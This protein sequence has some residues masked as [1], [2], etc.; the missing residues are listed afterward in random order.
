MSENLISRP[1]LTI[2]L[3]DAA[4]NLNKAWAIWFRDVYAR[5]GYQGGNILNDTTESIDD[6][7]DTLEEVIIQVDINTLD[8]D[9]NSKAIEEGSSSGLVQAQINHRVYGDSQ[10]DTY[11][12]SGVSY[13]IGDGV[14]YPETGDQ[15]Y[16]SAREAITD[17]AGTF[18]PLKWQKKNVKNSLSLSEA[19]LSL[20]TKAFH[21]EFAGRA[22]DG[23]ATLAHSSNI[24]SITRAG[25]GI[26]N[27]VISQQTFYG[28]DVLTSANIFSNSVIAPS[29]NSDLFHVEA[30]VTGATTFTVRVYEITVVGGPVRTAYDPV[31][32][33]FV[34]L[35][36]LTDVSSGVLPP[37]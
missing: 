36:A 23:V 29:V 28:E 30:W 33:D 21:V 18:D 17:P 12:T 8:I 5:I 2:P 27:G 31:G 25:A 6:T 4:G 37:A 19:I 9:D 3:N 14:Y 22:T 1:P 32:V 15:E 11:K 35:T 16:Y 20:P 10:P 13:A 26:Y 24:V 34:S 7:I